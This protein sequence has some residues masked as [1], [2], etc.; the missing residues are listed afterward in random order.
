VNQ[1]VTP[2]AAANIQQLAAKLSEYDFRLVIDG[3]G[4]MGDEDMNG[5][6]RWD[7]MQETCTQVARELSK[8]D[9][10][11][12][13]VAIF[14]GGQI[15]IYDKVTADKVKEVFANHR[16][17]GS[18]PMAEAVSQLLEFAKKSGSNKKQ[19]IP[20]FTDG[21]PDNQNALADVIRKQA[22]SQQNDDECT[23]L[24]IQVGHDKSASSYLQNLDDNL[25]GVK[26]D[27]VDAKTIEQV[28]KF[29]SVVELIAH[30]IND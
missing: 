24:F 20:I 5:K 7:H 22:N 11:G 3:S 17:S 15:K 8:I 29:P 27:I 19:F 6:S 12:I 10:D 14:S 4:S 18:T 9:T 13:T 21:L 28:D 30:A 1:T 26:F 25:S 2:P 16:P 23:F